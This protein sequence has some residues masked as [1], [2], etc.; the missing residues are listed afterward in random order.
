M[1]MARAAD[2]KARQ[3]KQEERAGTGRAN[4][5]PE[6]TEGEI[7]PAVGH[8]PGQITSK[9]NTSTLSDWLVISALMVLAMSVAESDECRT[10]STCTR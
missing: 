2:P 9:M 1:A 10:N 5:G 4:G 8:K 7:Y 3:A 6:Q